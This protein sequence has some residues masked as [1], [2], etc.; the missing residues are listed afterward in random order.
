MGAALHTRESIGST[1]A[2]LLHGAFLTAAAARPEATAL[3]C[4]DRPWHYGEIS[5]RASYMAEQ[6]REAGA[7]RGKLVAVLVEHGWQEV[8]GVLGVLGAGAAYLALDPRRPRHEQRRLLDGAASDLVL[9]TG[10]TLDGV[11]DGALGERRLLEMDTLVPPPGYAAHWR[12][13]P[14]PEDI[15]CVTYAGDGPHGPM[16][17]RL[18]HRAAAT[19][20]QQMNARLAVL[21]DDEILRVAPLGASPTVYDLFC[22]L[23]AGGTV[24]VPGHLEAASPA[25]CLDVIDDYGVTILETAAAPGL[26]LFEEAAHG[27]QSPLLSLR[28]VILA[29]RR[30]P[31]ELAR[32]VRWLLPAARVVALWSDRDAATGFSTERVDDLDR[33]RGPIWPGLATAPERARLGG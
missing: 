10:G 31:A 22:V 30:I 29:G 3:I 12:P 13:A 18:H 25:R 17:G 6:L 16:Y 27:H 20:L 1:S 26:A 7:G 24:I 9:A 23:S 5:R 14:S 32:R 2:T 4:D 21:D 8:V 33:S 28:L 11:A 15:A 19:L